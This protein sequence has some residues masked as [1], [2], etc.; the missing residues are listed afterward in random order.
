MK[1]ES[2]AAG[3]LSRGNITY[4]PVVPGRIEFALRVRRY[5]LEHR[6]R[7]IAVELPSSLDGISIALL[8]R[9]CRE[10]SVIVIPEQLA[11]MRKNTPPTSLLSL[12]IPSSRR[13]RTAQRARG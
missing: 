9:V 2:S 4:L 8:S 5:L 7:V 13:L 3:T 12:A 11:M 10:M 1:S 6:P